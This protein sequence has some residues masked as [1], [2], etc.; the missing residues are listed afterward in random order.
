MHVFIH[1]QTQGETYTNAQPRDTDI[2]KYNID[3]CNNIAHV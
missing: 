1:T 2:Y 3:R